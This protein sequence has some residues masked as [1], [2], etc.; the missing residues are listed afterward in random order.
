MT[1]IL[2]EEDFLNAQNPLLSPD[3]NNLLFTAFETDPGVGK[4][5][6][7]AGEEDGVGEEDEHSNISVIYTVDKKGRTDKQLETEPGHELESLNWLTSDT[8]A[9][10]LSASVKDEDEGTYLP[11]R[12][13]K[14]FSFNTSGKRKLLSESIIGKD[15]AARI[16]DHG[17]LLILNE[18]TKV[19]ELTD[20]LTGVKLSE[21]NGSINKAIRTYPKDTDTTV[22][23]VSKKRDSYIIETTNKPMWNSDV[24]LHSLKS[25]P[26]KIASLTSDNSHFNFIAWDDHGVYLQGF[27][28]GNIGLFYKYGIDNVLTKRSFPKDLNGCGNFAVGKLAYETINYPDPDFLKIVPFD[29]DD[30]ENTL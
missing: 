5:A 23:A 7:E 25:P 11:E 22:L 1:E 4:H 6:D 29:P 20:L 28:E 13:S 12:N 3:G 24:F 19:Y 15:S 27:R 10:L 8:F 30:N 16:L 14:L 21:L 17:V 2:K 18:N 26:V 9:Y